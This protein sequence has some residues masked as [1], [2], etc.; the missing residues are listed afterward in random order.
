MK[1]FAAATLLAIASAQFSDVTHPENT[2]VDLENSSKFIGRIGISQTFD[3]W[4][5]EREIDGAFL[6]VDQNP[7]LYQFICADGVNK[8]F[9]FSDDEALYVNHNCPSSLVH[10]IRFDI[11]LDT[12]TV[13]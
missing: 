6:N 10:K 5:D 3:E 11:T 2:R 12:D 9:P 7:C 13:L 8:P 1:S 4:V